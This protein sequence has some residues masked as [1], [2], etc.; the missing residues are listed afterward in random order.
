MED[1]KEIEERM[2]EG[3]EDVSPGEEKMGDLLHE[4][5][6]DIPERAERPR[7]KRRGKA[8]PLEVELDLSGQFLMKIC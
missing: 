6:A 3:E 8:L 1:F 2:Y 4:M 5:E 7:M